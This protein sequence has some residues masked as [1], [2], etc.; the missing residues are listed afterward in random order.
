M[1]EADVAT[2]QLVDV[3]RAVVIGTVAACLPDAEVIREDEADI[4]LFVTKQMGG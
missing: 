2:G 4:G 1:G 3:R